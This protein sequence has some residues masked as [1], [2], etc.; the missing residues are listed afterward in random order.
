MPPEKKEGDQSPHLF[1]AKVSKA[2]L[3]GNLDALRADIAEI[4][5]D[6]VVIIGYPASG[7][8]EAFQVGSDPISLTE[9]QQAEDDIQA[10]AAANDSDIFVPQFAS[11]VLNPQKSVGEQFVQAVKE[12]TFTASNDDSRSVLMGI[13]IDIVEGGIRLAAIDGFRLARSSKIP[14]SISQP[15]DRP[16]DRNGIVVDAKE[17][18]SMTRALARS[19]R[20]LKIM[21]IRLITDLTHLTI[22]A[23]QEPQQHF[24]FMRFQD[25]S[26]N[27]ERLIP[28]FGDPVSFRRQD[29]LNGLMELGIDI[30]HP[31]NSNGMED[32]VKIE[33]VQEGQGEAVR[34]TRRRNYLKLKE[35]TL[36]IRIKWVVDRYEDFEE[37]VL[38][39]TE[40]MLGSHVAISAQYIVE[41]LR[42]IDSEVLTIS[43]THP[44]SPIAIR[45]PND[46]D[47]VHVIMPM[48]IDWEKAT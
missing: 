31:V 37:E 2:R 43:S 47:F 15:E 34:L 44:G 40:E 46:P 23:G 10:P 21:D 4:E 16:E 8:I 35:D 14:I 29:F 18:S 24:S 19:K 41:A 11:E 20:K 32:I 13:S 9:L 27:V 26:P 25:V 45:K 42:Y 48:L 6:D 33:P 3:L 12:V 30:R 38:V 36:F 17:L 28:K 1:R 39:P 7:R 22:V 5:G